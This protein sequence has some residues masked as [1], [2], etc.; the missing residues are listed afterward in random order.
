MASAAQLQTRHT[1]QPIGKVSL[2]MEMPSKHRPTWSPDLV[3]GRMVD[4]RIR[5]G[6]E[7]KEAADR[8][9]MSKWNWYDK[10][11]GD[12]AF[13]VEQCLRFAAAVGAPTFFPLYDWNH[14]EE[15]DERLGWDK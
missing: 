14:A 3:R 6:L 15:L 4:A 13:T 2:P 8:A 9:G 11:D 12:T 1:T 7:V 5:L 10:E